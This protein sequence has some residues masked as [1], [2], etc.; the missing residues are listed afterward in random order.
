[1]RSGIFTW[2][3]QA[4]SKPGDA[5]PCD[6][7]IDLNRRRMALT[8]APALLP[9]ASA[10]ATA[11]ADT[12]TPL[13]AAAGYTSLVAHGGAGDGRTPDDRALIAAAQTGKPI[14]ATFAS[15]GLSDGAAIDLSGRDLILRNITLVADGHA[16]VAVGGKADPSVTITL[17][18][19]TVEAGARYLDYSALSGDL[20]A[21]QWLYIYGHLYGAWTTNGGRVCGVGYLCRV[22][23]VDR[24][25]RRI[26][27]Y[28]YIPEA[29]DTDTVD[30][31]SGHET[32]YTL[33]VTKVL[34]QRV[35]I[36]GLSLD[37]VSLLA[38]YVID[39]SVE[40]R[41]ADTVNDGF[42]LHVD[43]ANNL[44]V[45]ADSIARP[46]SGGRHSLTLENI[47][48]GVIDFKA[49]AVNFSN[50][51]KI[52]AVAKTLRANGLT[53]CE[54]RSQVLGAGLYANTVHGMIGGRF[55]AYTADPG[56]YDTD[57][58]I[59]TNN[60][61]DANNF[62]YMRR[63][64]Q[65]D[66]SCIELDSTGLEVFGAHDSEIIGCHLQKSR[67]GTPNTDCG[68]LSIKG[69]CRNLTVRNLHVQTRNDRNMVVRLEFDEIHRGVQQRDITFIAPYIDCDSYGISTRGAHIVKA[70]S[71][72]QAAGT[73]VVTARR[74]QLATGMRV[75]LSGY[76]Q[77]AYNGD[78]AITVTDA[79]SFTFP[80]VADAPA[81]ASGKG[82]ITVICDMRV[83]VL[84]GYI[85]ACRPVTQDRMHD[86]ITLDGT[87]CEVNLKPEATTGIPP[88]HNLTLLGNGNTLRNLNLTGTA[89]MERRAVASEGYGTTVENVQSDGGVLY[90]GAHLDRFNLAGLHNTNMKVQLAAQPLVFWPESD[91]SFSIDAKDADDLQAVDTGA[92]PQGYRVRERNAPS[93][94]T[95]WML[96]HGKWTRT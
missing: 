78:F 85:K 12:Q 45:T 95:G 41:L 69:I 61:N 36:A 52:G 93:R 37:R 17:A 20:D 63:G 31:G 67:A 24:Q 62:I 82:V 47:Y 7:H 77:A 59:T 48:G 73:A 6:E 26:W 27:L 43:I 54:V 53:H 11:R 80:L 33:T 4:F 91:G 65:V 92:W 22:R 75:R 68:M 21:D 86:N 64:A 32:T 30:D 40:A 51:T 1:M 38:R 55:T 83:R 8:L 76:D 44:R 34:P 87:T 56:T 39:S 15:H 28:H 25:A 18:A 13:P 74:H 19:S 35:D 10:A 58:H 49:S 79:D 94:D 29:L 5:K 96:A 50:A 2:F 42:G 9:I 46:T 66:V 71:V 23:Q 57:N 84:G 90:Q 3:R 14:D 70:T 60:R 81:Q 16:D 89:G 88:G 72:T